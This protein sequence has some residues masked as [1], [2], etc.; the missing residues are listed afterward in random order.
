MKGCKSL[1]VVAFIR[2]DQFGLAILNTVGS[3]EKWDL[4]RLRAMINMYFKIAFRLQWAKR[5]NTEQS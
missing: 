4:Q 5:I 3:I 2:I 1:E